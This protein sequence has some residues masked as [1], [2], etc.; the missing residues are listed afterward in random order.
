MANK[1]NNWIHNISQAVENKEFEKAEMLFLKD[2]DNIFSSFAL[3]EIYEVMNRVPKNYYV[4]INSKVM[5]GWLCFSNGNNINLKWVLTSISEKDID[6]DSVMSNYLALKSLSLFSTDYE[7][8][9]EYSKKAVDILSEDNKS[10]IKANAYMTYARQLATVFKYEE[11]ADAFQRAAELF[12]YNNCIFLSASCYANEGLN[13]FALGEFKIA[14]K[15]CKHHLLLAK[16]NDGDTDISWNLLK[17]PLAM[18]YYALNK[19]SLAI[20]E[21]KI[22]Y[23]TI[24]ELKL[25]HMH[26]LAEQYLFK[27]YYIEKNYIKMKDVINSLEDIFKNMNYLMIKNLI[28]SMKIEYRLST[29]KNILNEWIEE[30]EMNYDLH[31]KNTPF[32][33]IETFLQLKLK[34]FIKEFKLDDILKLF[35]RFKLEG[36]KSN[37][38]S[39]SLYIAELFY[40]NGDFDK[41]LEFIKKGYDIYKENGIYIHFLNRE[42]TCK[43]LIKDIDKEFGDNIEKLNTFSIKDKLIDCLT[44]REIEILKLISDG[45]SNKEISETLYITLGTTKW[46]IVNIYSKLS[47][48]NRVKAIDKAKELQLL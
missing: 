3:T 9:L 16:S 34:G 29:G 14:I 46:H 39:L 18:S 36:H 40:K 5:Y 19:T 37:L 20:K 2:I 25:P 43:K 13:R 27:I 6:D 42:L 32:F 38:Q 35:E 17:L 45:K 4:S 30:L 22:V 44:K 1:N 21:F 41:S 24:N 7:K 10:N 11:A 15:N 8:A 26:G 12:E 47:V 28:I 48:K 23:N 31:E 33:I